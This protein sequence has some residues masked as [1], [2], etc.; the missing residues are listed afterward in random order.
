MRKNRLARMLK[1]A[2]R[3]TDQ[4]SRFFQG[5]DRWATRLP[6]LHVGRCP[7]AVKGPA[8][9]LFPCQ[10]N[11]LCCGLAGLISVKGAPAG[12]A[13][14]D[15][16]GLIKL[17]EKV[18][19]AGLAAD[20]MEESAIQS[21]YLGGKAALTS[22]LAAVRALKKESAFLAL[23]KDPAAQKDLAGLSKRLGTVLENEQAQL[24][25]QAGS[26]AT[27]SVDI[28]SARIDVLK[29]I[30]W[31]LKVELADNI[32]R[33]VDLTG[34]VKGLDVDSRIRLLRQV[35]AVLN[36]IDRLE[37]RGRDSA[38]VSILFVFEKNDYDALLEQLG[39]DDLAR[40]L[41][42]RMGLDV[43]GNT[44]I[45]MNHTMDADNK[46]I[47]AL[48]VV[49]KIAAEIGSLGDN[50]RFLREQIRQDEIFQRIAATPRR[51]H[52]VSSHTRWASIGA[53]TEPNCHPVDNTMAGATMKDRP[54]IHACLNGDIDNYMQLK[55]I[56][57]KDGNHIPDC[58][59][60][61]TKIIPVLIEHY[62]NTGVDVTEAF[63]LAVSNFQGSHAI[64]MHTDL[65][66]GRFF[67][68]Q[69]GSGQAV[70]VGLADDH[71]MPASEVYGFI[72]E[73]PSFLKMNGEKVVDGKDGKTQGQLFVLD[74]AHGRRP[75]TASRPCTMTVRPSS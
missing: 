34:D 46:P 47:V 53:I 5:M 64:A 51:F 62:L 44:C 48:T 37:V 2:T 13:A 33:V 8:I 14:L 72:E 69:K 60:T 68:A 31:T 9:V 71:Y 18:E 10:G 49:Y 17:A 39:K 25:G 63:R 29:D 40:D 32:D 58:I 42:A 50:I 41:E 24:A 57:E 22:L 26:L 16:P 74:P 15:L 73:T 36:S 61:D 38:G 3:A 23:Y 35:N 27:A 55:E 66:P 6:R 7:G 65:A 59:T 56:V 4:M 1:P 70:F 43:L 28:V 45:S 67:L 54:I 20:A 30:I 75:W 12:D 11:M 19:G 21:G 52:T